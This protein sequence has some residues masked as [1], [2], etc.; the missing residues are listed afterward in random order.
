MRVHLVLLLW[1][2]AAPPPPALPLVPCATLGM[3]SNEKKKRHD[4]KNK[5]KHKTALSLSL[6]L[7]NKSQ[8]QQITAKK[9]SKEQ[10]TACPRVRWPFG[11][12]QHASEVVGGAGAVAAAPPHQIALAERG[13]SRACF[14]FCA[15]CAWC[16]WCAWCAVLC[17]VG[18]FS[19]PPACECACVGH[20][21]RVVMH[22]LQAAEGGGDLLVLQ[23][24]GADVRP[25]FSY[26]GG[27]WMFSLI[28]FWFF[29]HCTKS[30]KSHTTY[31]RA[32]KPHRRQHHHYHHHHHHQQHA[33]V[34]TFE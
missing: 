32:S 15:S 19:Q 26:G 21:P 5:I 14:A 1:R 13:R 28:Y 29:V 23:Q 24:H 6:S 10:N 3:R 18:G 8:R 12:L 17:V 34:L 31:M 4:D 33:C 16:A 7:K 22:L 9:K 25:V 30:T 27:E 20:A 11:A 2:H